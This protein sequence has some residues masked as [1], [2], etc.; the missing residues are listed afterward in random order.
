MRLL[1]VTGFSLWCSSFCVFPRWRRLLYFDLFS[2]WPTS[3]QTRFFVMQFNCITGLLN[4]VCEHGR[5]CEGAET[6]SKL[7]ANSINAVW[8]GLSL[9]TVCVSRCCVVFVSSFE[10]HITQTNATPRCTL[11]PCEGTA[12][13]ERPKMFLKVSFKDC[14][15]F[16]KWARVFAR[17]ESVNMWILE[18]QNC[19]CHWL[20]DLD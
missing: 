18:S 16:I 14:Y 13:L 5:Y 20:W 3:S 10:A 17:H 11:V 6:F 4:Y 2:R 9:R 8:V 1:A 15:A 19:H 12:S 7:F